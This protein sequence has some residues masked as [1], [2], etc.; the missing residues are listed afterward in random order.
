[1]INFATQQHH[2]KEV[3]DSQQ[4]SQTRPWLEGK[5]SISAN[6]LYPTP[7]P[8]LLQHLKKATVHRHDEKAWH[9]PGVSSFSCLLTEQSAYP[10]LSG[11]LPDTH[12]KHKPENDAWALQ[13]I[14]SWLMTILKENLPD[15]WLSSLDVFTD[16]NSFTLI[17]PKTSSLLPFWE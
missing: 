2:E 7:I 10:A 17:C 9:V 5:K 13:H 8:W 16:K 1:M 12:C 14:P 3:F 6:S 11:E 15:K 4:N